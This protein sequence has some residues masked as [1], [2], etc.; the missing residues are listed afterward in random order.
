M[1]SMAIR[2]KNERIHR[3]AKELAAMTGETQ[4]A[5]ICRALENDLA[6]IERFRLKGDGPSSIQPTGQHSLEAKP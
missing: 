4:V 2:T 5:A 1:F 3:L 6:E